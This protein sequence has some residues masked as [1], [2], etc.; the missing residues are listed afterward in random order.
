MYGTLA[1][2]DQPS[3][4]R[5]K[6]NLAQDAKLAEGL[7]YMASLNPKEP[8]CFVMLG[9]ASWSKGDLNLATAAFDKAT[10]L[11]SLQSEILK[12]K[13]KGLRERIQKGQKYRSDERRRLW[14]LYLAVLAIVGA[15]G[16]FIGGTWL[17]KSHS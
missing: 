3:A 6:W 14:P 2:L 13:T 12:L 8:A 15:I 17:R 1:A 9:V 7:I 16:L 4:Y 11:G 5:G 10:K